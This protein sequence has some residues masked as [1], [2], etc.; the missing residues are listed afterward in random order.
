[1]WNELMNYVITIWQQKIT[2]GNP[3]QVLT[4]YNIG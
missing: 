1:V 2:Y 3:D 4:V